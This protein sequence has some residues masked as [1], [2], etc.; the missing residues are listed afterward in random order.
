MIIMNEN[1]QKRK[2]EK[3]TALRY[4]ISEILRQKIRDNKIEVSQLSK[5]S[6]IPQSTI[7]H[8]LSGDM[9]KLNYLCLL[10]STTRT[11]HILQLHNIEFILNLL[12]RDSADEAHYPQ[13]NILPLPDGQPASTYKSLPDLLIHIRTNLLNLSARGAARMSE[14]CSRNQ[15]ESI[16][17]KYLSVGPSVLYRCFESYYQQLP[18]DSHNEHLAHFATLLMQRLLRSAYNYTF[19]LGEWKQK[20]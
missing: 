19:V 14:R 11:N 4:Y 12:I 3:H 18:E 6:G 10:S 1:L 15:I 8:F 20:L 5:L 7:Y 13:F 2:P 17:K 9:L 16:E